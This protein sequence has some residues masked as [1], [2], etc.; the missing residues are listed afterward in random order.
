V[1]GDAA[2]RGNILVIG[3]NYFIRQ[4]TTLLKIARTTNDPILAATLVD[5]AVKLKSQIDDAP[6]IQD[7]SP[8]AP[9]VE[10]PA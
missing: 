10:R 2:T 4:A 3:R 6:P 7:Q 1:V 9:D 5:R 8:Q